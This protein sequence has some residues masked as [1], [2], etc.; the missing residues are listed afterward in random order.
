MS[1]VKEVLKQSDGRSIIV[2]ENGERKQASRARLAMHPVKPGD[3]Y[4][5]LEYDVVESDRT[6]KPKEVAKKDNEEQSLLE[7]AEKV[8]AI[9]KKDNYIEFFA[10]NGIDDSEATKNSIRRD[11]LQKWIKNNTIFT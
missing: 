11:L 8:L 3:E 10:A 1:K 6:V 7:T 4:E 5:K 2:L 9:D